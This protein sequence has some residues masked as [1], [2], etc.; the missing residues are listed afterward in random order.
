[1]ISDIT[2]KKF[3]YLTVIK[4][5]GRTKNGVVKWLCK[6]DCGNQTVVGGWNL[7][8]GRTKSCGC[9]Q[10]KTVTALATKHSQSKTS[11]YSAWASMRQRCRNEKNP[12]YKN[13]GA[14]GVSV[15]SE[16]SEFEPFMKWAISSGYKKGLTID[17][18]D[19]NDG[20]S[21]K[22][23]R[24]VSH[25]IQANN[26]RRNIITKVRGED[27]TLAQI[28]RKYSLP[29]RKLSYRFSCGDRGENLIRGGNINNG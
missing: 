22:N 18:I 4:Q 25:R 3:G 28:A 24:W 1:M 2:G 21:P 15:C 26:T 27:L 17:R 14:R 20:Y 23:C 29:Y 11:L 10:K 6:C 19:N 7:R 13:Y 16:W 12:N 9:L 8:S 5:A